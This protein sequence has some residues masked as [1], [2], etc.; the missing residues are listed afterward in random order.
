MWS[1]FKKNKKIDE[2]IT[3]L[4][5]HGKLVIVRNVDYCPACGKTYGQ[6]DELLGIC[7]EHRITK[8]FLEIVTYSAQMIPGF[9]NS[10]EVLWKLK[11]I[12]ISASQIKILSGEVGKKLF[13]RQMEKANQSYAFP[14]IAA[15]EAL[16]KDKKDT[17]LY[18]LMDGSAVNTRIED[19]NGSTWKEMK[20]G[21]T[22][23][24]KDVIRRKNDSGI[25]TKKEYVTYL[26]S[27]NEFKKLVFD[28]AA[29]AGYGKVKKVVVIG[30]GAHWIWNMCKELFPDAECILDFYH[31]SENVY[32]YAKELYPN[33]VK[34]YKKWAETV[35]Y[36]I[37][38]Q[39]LKK[40]LEKIEAV[41]IEIKEDNNIVNLAGYIRNNLDKINYLDYKNK[42]Y[43]IGS[44]MIEAGNKVVIQKRMKQA[45]MRWGLEN[46]Q[47]M[48]ALRA[49]HESKMWR[50]VE[51]IIYDDNAA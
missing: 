47:Y 19:E 17:V 50:D 15:R 28:S 51:D 27:V 26:G 42:G 45:G 12:D 24:D 46:G 10:K 25:I 23:L 14:E 38:T 1:T 34:K 44:G 39:Q 8:D 9:E 32:S 13:E 4:T 43:Y 3:I 5:P 30:D 2:P 20:L 11:G 33:N 35:I 36:Y 48:A 21:L 31:V 7:G 16:D 29:K 6:N 37:E 40:A 18:I 41:P 22:F 49:K